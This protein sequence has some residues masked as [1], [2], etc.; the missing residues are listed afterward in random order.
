[1]LV[2]P[3]GSIHQLSLLCFFISSVV[4]LHLR[5][6]AS[7]RADR[8]GL[9]FFPRKGAGKSRPVDPANFGITETDYA[10][11]TYLLCWKLWQGG[12][13]V[14]LGWERWLLGNRLA[15]E[16]QSGGRLFTCGVFLDWNG[17]PGLGS[18][19]VSSSCGCLVW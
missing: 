19:L 18:R 11:L 6:C 1:M 9:A 12:L 17:V 16:G 5:S 2:I 10:S 4:I 3:K 13:L 15:G 8:S 7:G 14:R